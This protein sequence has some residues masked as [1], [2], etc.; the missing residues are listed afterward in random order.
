MQLAKH[1]VMVDWK[2]GVYSHT[3]NDFPK[4][5]SSFESSR[6]YLW[7]VVFF[8]LKENKLSVN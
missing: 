5:E 6:L 4:A 7:V 8:F 2:E 1:Q 3:E